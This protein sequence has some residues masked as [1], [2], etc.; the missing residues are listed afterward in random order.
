MSTGHDVRTQHFRTG[1]ATAN[2]IGALRP[3]VATI[4]HVRLWIRAPEKN[5]TVLPN[6]KHVKLALRWLLRERHRRRPVTGHTS[7]A[8]LPLDRPVSVVARYSVPIATSLR[9]G[10]VSSTTFR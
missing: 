6:D 10:L 9:L 4:M 2:A 5:N 7:R 1:T 8:L 3:H